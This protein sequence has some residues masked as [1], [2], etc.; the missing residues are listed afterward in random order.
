MQRGC[1]RRGGLGEGGSGQCC[2]AAA[3]ILLLYGLDRGRRP[4]GRRNGGFGG[5]RPPTENLNDFHNDFPPAGEDG[6]K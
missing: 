5:Q 1:V 4:G 6:G 2:T 3:L